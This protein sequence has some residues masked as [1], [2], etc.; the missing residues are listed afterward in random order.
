MTSLQHRL[1]RILNHIRILSIILSFVTG[2]AFTV[3]GIWLVSLHGSS[4][5]LIAGITYLLLTWLVARKKPLA[6]ALSWVTFALTLIW[7]LQEVG[8]SYWGMMPRIFL[9]LIL[10][11]FVIVASLSFEGLKTLTRRVSVVTGG[12]LTLVALVFFGFAFKPHGAVENL[13]G[14]VPLDDALYQANNVQS[15]EDWSY[16]G[17]KSTGTRFA[18]YEQITKDNVMDLRVAWTYHTGRQLK[19]RGN[20]VAGVDENTPLQVGNVLYACTPQSVVHAIDADSGKPIW[21]FDP[22]AEATE[23]VT[24]R[25]VGFY[26]VAKDTTLPEKVRNDA[27][28]NGQCA[29]RIIV[30]SVDARMFAVD[31]SSGK[32]CE[33]FGQAGIVDL[34]TGMGDTENGV[35]YHP[36]ASPVV[37]GHQ[38]IIGGW[39]RDLSASAISGVVR[40]FDVISGKQLWAWDAGRN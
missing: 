19:T 23:H 39:S 40:S 3:G 37:M 24:C 38:V 31:A 5:Y 32:A 29:R 36:T 9:P 33:A 7:A 2:A 30:T 16:F 22:K 26:D 25:S 4:Y 11:L 27:L 34:K 1:G 28:T 17:R 8:L 35:L 12:V 21:T 6:I 15:S 13:T 14:D 18:P 10:F 20:N